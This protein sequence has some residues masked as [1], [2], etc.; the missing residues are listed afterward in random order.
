MMPDMDSVSTHRPR[1]AALTE[2]LLRIVAERG[3]DQVSVR[4]VATEAGVSIGTVQ[5]YFPTKDAMLAG[6]FAEVVERVRVRLTAV[7]LGP[8]IRR[9]LSAVLAELLPLDERRAVEARVQLSFA[10]RATHS[11][12]LAAIQRTVLSEVH[13]ALT[14]AFVRASAGDA[15]TSTAKLAAHAALAAVD[16]L[17]LHA[18]SAPGWLTSRRLRATLDLLLDALIPPSGSTT[19][20]ERRG[21]R[22]R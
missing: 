12:E 7:E 6:A 9:N 21:R 22:P 10:A 4:E 16:G 18:M 5:H 19:P 20:G 15:T 17:A 14:D 8:D 1:E 11:A 2:A 13:D 3:L